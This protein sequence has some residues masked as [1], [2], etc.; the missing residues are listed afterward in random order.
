VSTTIFFFLI[1]TAYIAGH[2]LLQ[3]GGTHQQC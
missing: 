2:G 1:T 3:E